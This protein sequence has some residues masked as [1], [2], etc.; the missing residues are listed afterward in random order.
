M[1]ETGIHL[2]MSA[3]HISGIKTVTSALLLAI[4]FMLLPISSSCAG[5]SENTTEIYM[6]DGQLKSHIIRIYINKSFEG[7]ASKDIYLKLHTSA[8]PMAPDAKQTNKDMVKNATSTKKITIGLEGKPQPIAQDNHH[9]W[10]KPVQDTT[11]QQY[12][13]MLLFNLEGYS[14]PY[15]KT[16]TRVLP[17]L[18]WCT[19]KSAADHAKCLDYDNAFGEKEVYLANAT[20]SY[21][22]A[23]GTIVVLIFLLGFMSMKVHGRAIYLLCDS[24][25]RLSLS[26]TQMALWTIAIGGIVETFGLTRFD[27]PAIPGTLLGLMGASLATTTISHA[28][29]RIKG[30]TQKE[31]TKQPAIKKRMTE[32]HWYDL[33][34][35]DASNSLALVRAQM[36][37]WT[38]ITL[39]MFVT[40]SILDGALWQVPVELVGL[41]GMSQLAYLAPK[42]IRDTP[43]T[44]PSKP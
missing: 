1:R 6:P 3:K 16:A 24:T 4:C 20:G 22:W 42:M 30:D 14:I 2:E 5:E 9:T 43:P 40:K 36:L 15:Y 11:I 31:T 37:F 18:V 28:K 17:E 35:D 41:M 10:E 23:A 32:P 12:G 7:I 39:G 21:L 44:E 8:A 33:I 34:S 25:G 29:S 38:I 13:T 26:R 19:K 27:V